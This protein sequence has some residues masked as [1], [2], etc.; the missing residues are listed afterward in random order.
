MNLLKTPNWT[1]LHYL[2]HL[3]EAFVIWF[4]WSL[5]VAYSQDFCCSIFTRLL[6]LHIHEVTSGDHGTSYGCS[7][8]FL[9]CHEEEKL[10]HGQRHMREL[11][12][13]CCGF[14]NSL[15]KPAFWWPGFAFSWGRWQTIKENKESNAC[16]TAMFFVCLFIHKHRD[17]KWI[18][19]GW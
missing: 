9:W 12:T 7:K 11:C 1:F 13:R 4:S 18:V 19:S 17:I 6:L 16:L 15:T 5:A 8:P 3:H 2:F 14:C 10:E